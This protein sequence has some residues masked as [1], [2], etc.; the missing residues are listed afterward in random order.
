MLDRA[1]PIAAPRR[2]QTKRLVRLPDLL[3]RAVMR[4]AMLASLARNARAI[5]AV[6][7]PPTARRVERDLRQ[8]S[9]FVRRSGLPGCSVVREDYAAWI[10]RQES[11]DP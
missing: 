2:E 1:E 8:E 10:E 9:A 7:R 11:L 5:C 3:F 4:W 6:V